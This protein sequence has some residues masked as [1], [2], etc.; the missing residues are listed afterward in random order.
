MRLT[1]DFQGLEE[2]RLII[3]SR[4]MR[5]NPHIDWNRWDV[6]AAAVGKRLEFE[7]Y[8]PSEFQKATK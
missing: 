4:F 1:F 3:K 7:V 5:L 8:K 6:R 2:I